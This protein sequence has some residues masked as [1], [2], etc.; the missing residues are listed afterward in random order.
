MTGWNVL[1][2]VRGAGTGKSRLRALGQARPAVSRALALDTIAAVRRCSSV[3]R[4][5]VVTADRVFAASLPRG[6]E[7]VADEDAAGIDAAL[8]I[9]AARLG[10]GADRAALPGDLPALEAGELARAL[11]AALQVPRGAVADAEGTGTTL[12]TATAGT[13]WLSSYGPGSF[14]RHLALGCA[15]LEV[16]ADSG[17]RCD[18]DTPEQLS[19]LSARLGPRTA[20]AWLAARDTARVRQAIGW[21]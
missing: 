7:A 3:E 2:P 14:A 16:A 10:E 9:G 12:V 11:D 8:R 18:V 20:R 13:P 21:G 6:V 15:A 4:V 1:I 5:V 17:L 19:A